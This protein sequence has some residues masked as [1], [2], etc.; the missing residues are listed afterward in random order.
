MTKSCMNNH[1]GYSLVKL[2]YANL[3]AERNLNIVS[4]NK[5]FDIKRYVLS[6]V[7]KDHIPGFILVKSFRY[8]NV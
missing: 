2:I 4:V 1:V 3:A 6:T 5:G 7:V 8:L